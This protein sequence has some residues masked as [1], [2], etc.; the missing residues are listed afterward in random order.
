M[1][2]N[3]NQIALIDRIKANENIRNLMDGI[4]LQFDI[5]NILDILFQP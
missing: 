2:K 4:Y 5:L 1:S 3:F